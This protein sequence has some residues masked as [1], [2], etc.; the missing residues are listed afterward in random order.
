MSF[1]HFVLAFQN[2]IEHFQDLVRVLSD[3]PLTVEE[4][5][6]LNDSQNVLIG[7]F[8]LISLVGVDDTS[9]EGLIELPI[10]IVS[11]HS[12]HGD[13]VLISS[14]FQ[15]ALKFVEIG[16][17]FF[18]LSLLEH[19]QSVVVKHLLAFGIYQQF[20]IVLQLTPD[21]LVVPRSQKVDP[22]FISEV[23]RDVSSLNQPRH[24]FSRLLVILSPEICLCKYQIQFGGLLDRSHI[25]DHFVE[26]SPI[27][28]IVSVQ[29]VEKFI[30]GGRLEVVV[31]KFVPE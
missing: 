8:L 10:E 21:Q 16:N 1:G 24:Q 30:G 22:V 23:G 18:V 17:S 9:V 27:V 26:F 29:F 19:H 12:H 13:I 15:T 7:Y 5:V 11:E 4:E 3:L 20:L 14:L 25:L 28:K 31:G 6:V 2:F